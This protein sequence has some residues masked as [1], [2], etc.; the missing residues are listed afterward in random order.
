MIC[1]LLIIHTL[2]HCKVW[3][4]RKKGFHFVALQMSDEMPLDIFRKLRGLF[5]DLLDVVLAKAAMASVI[6]LAD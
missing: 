6:D 2:N 5:D 1:N 3:D 4:S